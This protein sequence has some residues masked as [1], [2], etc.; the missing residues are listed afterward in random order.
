M[1]TT[2]IHLDG[3][4]TVGDRLDLVGAE[5]PDGEL[6]LFTERDVAQIH[7]G[8][9]FRY[10]YDDGGSFV[11]RAVEHERDLGCFGLVDVEDGA[12]VDTRGIDQTEY[13]K[14]AESGTIRGLELVN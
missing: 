7:D 3:L 6:L 13:R 11:V 14:M 8:D 1:N 5:T 4:D 10:E 2:A 12:V 9:H